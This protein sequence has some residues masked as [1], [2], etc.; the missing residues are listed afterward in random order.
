MPKKRLWGWVKLGIYRVT[1]WHS[2]S[3]RTVAQGKD[4]ALSTFSCCH[5]I[6]CHEIKRKRK[7]RNN[8]SERSA[9]RLS[10]NKCHH[11]KKKKKEA[12]PLCRGTKTPPFID[13]AHA[14]DVPLSN[15]T[16]K[17]TKSHLKSIDES[18]V[19]L[20]HQRTVKR[21]YH[22]R[23]SSETLLHKFIKSHHLLPRVT[24][25]VVYP[26]EQDYG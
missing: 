25:F 2:A 16:T 7:R 5:R 15:K 12:T 24:P 3:T 1:T 8:A 13:D 9:S 20:P 18:T 14:S 21:N 26:V 11:R 4:R 17:D 23:N 6:A 10:L 19:D 22:H